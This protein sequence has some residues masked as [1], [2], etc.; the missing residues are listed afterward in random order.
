M[1]CLQTPALVLSNQHRGGSIL[2]CRVYSSDF[3]GYS[4]GEYAGLVLC[5]EKPGYLREEICCFG[6]AVQISK[7]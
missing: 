1:T 2:I 4:V 3:E 5:S 7:A 6:V